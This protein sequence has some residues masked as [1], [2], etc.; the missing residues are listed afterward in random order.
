ML[1][2]N[3]KN[4]GELLDCIR[5]KIFIDSFEFELAYKVNRSNKYGAIE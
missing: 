1:F 3:K 2:K 5:C 4:K